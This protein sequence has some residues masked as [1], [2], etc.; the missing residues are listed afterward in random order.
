MFYIPK[1][2]KMLTGA[3]LKYEYVWSPLLYE[4]KI[5][6]YDFNVV[7]FRPSITSGSS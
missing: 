2:P 3:E 4:L 6:Y 5:H 7:L 1:I